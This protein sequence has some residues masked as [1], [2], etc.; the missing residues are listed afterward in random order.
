MLETLRALG[1]ARLSW[2]SLTCMFIEILWKRGRV[3]HGVASD[4]ADGGGS[5]RPVL[6]SAAAI[7]ALRWCGPLPGR[8]GRARGAF[9]SETLLPNHS[10]TR[11]WRFSIPA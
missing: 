4:A 9:A 1:I 11:A 10:I 8:M 3:G 5:T 7:H 6:A 2:G